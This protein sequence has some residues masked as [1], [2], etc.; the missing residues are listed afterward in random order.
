MKGGGTRQRAALALTVVTIALALAAACRPDPGT[1]EAVPVPMP[2]LAAVEPGVRQQITA[3]K[4][5]LDRLLA[6]GDTPAVEL[7]E[8]Y[9]DLG[10]VFLT[11]EYSEPAEAALVNAVRLAPEEL[12]WTY[13]LG[14]L[15]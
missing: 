1:G 15:H 13:L 8:A 12:R 9:G 11:Y 4:A 14:Y 5:E 6:A 3:R 2:E 7:A 10:L